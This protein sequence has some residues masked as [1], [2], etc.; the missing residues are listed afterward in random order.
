[1]A[2]HFNRLRTGA[3]S[4]DIANLMTWLEQ[5]RYYETVYIGARCYGLTIG[6]PQL[7]GKL[8][9][10]FRPVVNLDQLCLPF[11]RYEPLR[12]M[13]VYS[14][15]HPAYGEGWIITYEDVFN[16]HRDLSYNINQRQAVNRI[17]ALSIYEKVEVRKES[18]DPFGPTH[19]DTQDGPPTRCTGCF[20]AGLRH[21]CGSLRYGLQ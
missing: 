8:A 12:V 2:N 17:L 11:D 9:R 10:W 7:Y 21:S 18:E 19:S 5:Q 1:M 3:N 6:P 16:R 15:S 13:S 4:L 20:R 14:N